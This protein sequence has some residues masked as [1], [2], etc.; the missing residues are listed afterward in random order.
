MGGKAPNR[1]SQPAEQVD[2]P[3]SEGPSTTQ[4]FN[5]FSR[6]GAKRGRLG[7]RSKYVDV[8]NPGGT[9]SESSAPPPIGMMGAPHMTPGQLPGSFF[10]PQ[11]PPGGETIDPHCQAYD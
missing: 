6:A 10:V 4:P 8:M 7:A 2:G 3:S 5:Q 11:L 1:G 9:A